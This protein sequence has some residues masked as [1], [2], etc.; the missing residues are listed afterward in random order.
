M[1]PEDAEGRITA[2]WRGL[3]THEELLILLEDDRE[4]TMPGNVSFDGDATTSISYV[5][6]TALFTL[7]EVAP[8]T[9][10][11]ERV[12]D[13][14]IRMSGKTTEIVTS[15]YATPWEKPLVWRAADVAP[16]GEP[17]MAALQDR[18]DDADPDMAARVREIL[19]AAGPR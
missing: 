16:F 12:A 11:V 18:L 14:L 2:C 13:L 9:A 7:A 10:P 6:V 19:A 15:T 4:H 17:L 3:V 1:I 8:A 5:S